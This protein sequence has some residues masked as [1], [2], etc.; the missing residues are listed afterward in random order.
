MGAS[1][2][3]QVHGNKHMMFWSRDDMIAGKL[4]IYPKAHCMFRRVLE[5]ATSPDRRLFPHHD[6]RGTIQAELVPGEML[7]W[8]SM[9][10][11][12]TTATTKSVS[13]GKRSHARLQD[14]AYGDVMVG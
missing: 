13:I 14:D 7:Y 3:I 9:W 6:A 2:L 12:F 11:H 5:D 1:L 8:P 4:N 10:A